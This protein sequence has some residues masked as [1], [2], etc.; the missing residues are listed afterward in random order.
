MRLRLGRPDIARYSDRFTVPPAHA[1]SDLGVT[2]MGVSTLL[3][4]AGSSAVM[5]DGF[6]SRPNL[7]R[8]GL[9]QIEP[10]T[11]RIAHALARVNARHL[12]AIMPV[13]TH[14]DHALDTAVVAG[15]TSATMV[16]GKSAANIARGHGLAPDRIVVAVPG[17][18]MGFGDFTI[19]MIESNHCPPDRFPG[20]ID[21]PV[22][23]RA[24]TAAY[25]CGEAWSIFITHVPSGRRA[26]VQGSAGYVEASLAGQQ[27]EVVYLGIGQLGVQS[28]DYVRT[29]WHETVRTVGA[30]VAVLIHWDD[31]FR[32]LDQPLR[33]LPYAGD[34]LDATMRVLSELA[35][36]EGVQLL[37]PS[38]FRREDPW[39]LL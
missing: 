20:T 17:A 13:H 23:L 38:V 1:A 21:A 24:K 28:E 4:D 33:A 35:S 18:D 29:Y 25:R 14:F 5:T 37:F 27:A 10:N 32:P 7:L 9:G 39:L 31:F 19:T 16:G 30:H 2:F 12:Q 3:F 15:R 36:A 11:N 6:F 22:A 34:D 26:L 8:V